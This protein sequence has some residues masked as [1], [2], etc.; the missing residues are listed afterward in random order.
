MAAVDSH[1]EYVPVHG[2]RQQSAVGRP[3]RPGLTI[4][5]PIA[6]VALV[7]S[8][9]PEGG[10]VR[11][12]GVGWPPV[13]DIV[14]IEHP[15]RY[16]IFVPSRDQATPSADQGSAASARCITPDPFTANKS[17]DNPGL[18]RTEAAIRVPSGDQ[19]IESI[20]PK[21]RE[22]GLTPVPSGCM[23]KIWLSFT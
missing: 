5:E 22:S 6:V 15:E 4:D 19:E 14:Q 2:D 17:T 18:G 7:L 21:A 11:S 13:G 1:G 3:H 20:L 8:L 9:T 23:T 16:A 10:R 12:L